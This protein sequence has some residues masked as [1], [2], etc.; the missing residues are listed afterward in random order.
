M[1]RRLSTISSPESAEY[2]LYKNADMNSHTPT[3]PYSETSTPKSSEP[4]TITPSES[5]KIQLMT[6]K[7]SIQTIHNRLDY[8]RTLTDTD[9]AAL[10]NR[11]PILQKEVADWV[12][13][14]ANNQ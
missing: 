1:P 2:N 8:D 14:T 4:E 11:L 10:E 7:D 12:S 13:E 9:R 3:V 5:T 6:L